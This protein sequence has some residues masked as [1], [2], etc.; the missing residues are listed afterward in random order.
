MLRPAYPHTPPA[1]PESAAPD[2]P[3]GWWETGSHPPLEHRPGGRIEIARPAEE[4]RQRSRQG[5]HH[6]APRCPRGHRT[7]ARRELREVGIPPGWKLA[8]HGAIELAGEVGVRLRQA[9]FACRQAPRSAV[10]RSRTLANSSRASPGRRRPALP[11]S[12]TP[13]LSAGPPRH[14]AAPRGRGRCPACGGFH[15]RYECAR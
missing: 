1:V 2:R 11:A 13:V 8:G 5:L 9:P 14:R 15:S 4:I 7:V 3:R 10:P 6:L 12:R